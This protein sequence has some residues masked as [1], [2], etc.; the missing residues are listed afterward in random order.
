MSSASHILLSVEVIYLN[1]KHCHTHT[2][3][4]MYN[5]S[6]QKC[7]KIDCFVEL[8]IQEQNTLFNFSSGFNR[9]FGYQ[10]PA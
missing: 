3:M 6:H 7:D 5:I 9:P 1:N 2:V 10:Q 8:T 4:I